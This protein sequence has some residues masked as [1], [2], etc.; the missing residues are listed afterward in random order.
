MI[1][2]PPD[3]LVHSS[4]DSL[5]HA[6]G[7]TLAKAAYIGSVQAVNSEYILIAGRTGT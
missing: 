1:C 2:A 4:S 6:I 3:V 7:G 5:G